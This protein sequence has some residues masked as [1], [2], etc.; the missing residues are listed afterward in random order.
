MHIT[1]REV[2]ESTRRRV[3]RRLMPFLF[4]LYVIA[5]IDRINI[6]FAGLQMTGEL[7]FSDAVFGLGSGLFFLGYVPLGIPGALLVERWS[8]R[9]VMAATLVVW[10]CVASATGL[11]QT[12]HQFYGMRLLLGVAEAGF[13]PGVITYLGH[14]YRA[15]DRAKAVAMFM[16]AIP[17]AQVIA[18]PIS[19]SLMSVDWLG[20]SGWR[21]LLLLEGAPAVVAGIASWV[22]LTDRPAGARW[23]LPEQAAWLSGELE[24]EKQ[25]M[26]LLHKEKISLWGAMWH[27]DVL[28]LCGAYFGAAVGNYGL[29]L[30]MP[31]MLQQLGRLTAG[32][33][34]ML[35][36][37]PAVVAVPAMLWVG[38]RSDR[39]G[40]RRWHTAAPRL[41]AG[42]ALA[43]LA[44]YTVGVP[45]A[46]VLFSIAL[47]GI[48]AAYP[49]QWAIPGSFLSA[50]AAAASIGFINSFGNIGGLAGP[51]LIGWFSDR[52]GGS[53]VGGLWCMVIAL[54]ASGV[55]VVLVRAR[56]GRLVAGGESPR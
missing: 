20:L 11:I 53:Y 6:S 37:I 17:V 43:V 29:G 8:A 15:E 21:W 54:A 41:A 13:F 38:W 35:S 32:E 9:K 44:S 48:V 30:W 51:Y 50:S 23:L 1:D 31:K 19:A 3:T 25:G 52:T 40:E 46:L 14:W 4:F 33:T 26:A 27:R 47:S 22:Y 12:A 18:S 39:T 28:L 45:V 5:Y 24:R 49:P 36:A 42:G 7:H 2:A 34:T 56:P 10:G 55:F 16:I